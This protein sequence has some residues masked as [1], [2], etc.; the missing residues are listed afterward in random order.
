MQQ[1]KLAM[2]FVQQQQRG[3]T[4]LFGQQDKVGDIG[5]GGIQRVVVISDID[6]AEVALRESKLHFFSFRG[7]RD[8]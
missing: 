7:S 5:T 8:D 1:G 4:G 3:L 2:D 6:G